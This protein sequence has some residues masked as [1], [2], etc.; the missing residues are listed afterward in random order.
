MRRIAG[1][2]EGKATKGRLGALAYAL[3]RL[4]GRSY[5]VRKT[6]I[7]AMSLI[8]PVR[9]PFAHAAN[10]L[11][12]MAQLEVNQEEI[13]EGLKTCGFSQ[14]I[15]LTAN[16][17]TAIQAW[18]E[19]NPCYADRNPN[20]GLHASQDGHRN[21]ELKLGKPVLVAQYFNTMTHCATIRELA[22]DPMLYQIASDYFG[23][24]PKM[25][26]V[27]LW[28]TF[29]TTK[30]E[31]EM[32]KHA[33]FFHRDLDDFK[34]IKFFFHITD[35]SDGDG[36]HTIVSGSYKEK[37]FRSKLGFDALGRFSDEQIQK[38]FGEESILPMLG[39]A[40]EGFVEDTWTIH[41]GTPPIHKAR[42]MLQIQY[43]GI[44]YG[45][46]HDRRDKTALLDPSL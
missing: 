43:A 44:D 46:Q 30:S 22:Q 27:N 31:A 9:A 40:G 36:A 18:A 8:R 34:F 37:V 5:I 20:Y 1:I 14:G 11:N 23:F 24:A 42:L 38:N 32:M 26:G 6:I 45:M 7:L 16:A 35:C 21:A 39:R 12:Q 19:S 10:A 29:P 17:L 3:M 15:R 25:V 33:H 13:V 2:G 28:W 4:V 41:K